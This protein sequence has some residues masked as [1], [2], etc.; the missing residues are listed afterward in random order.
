MIKG[1]KSA[2]SLGLWMCTALVVGNMIGSGVFLLPASLAPY[3]AISILG[4][5]FTSAGAILLALS[6]AR[7]SRRVPGAGGPYTYSRAGFGDFT[8]FLVAWGY[9]ISI[10]SGNAAISVAFASYL[11]VFLPAIG[12]SNRLAATAS[13]LA[14]WTLTIVNIA[15][16]RK[17]GVVQLVTT[18]MKLVPLVGIAIFG[19]FY[20]DPGHFFP[21]NPSNESNFSAVSA[22]AALTLW[23]FLG[24]ESA[25]I[26]A[27]DIRNPSKTIPRSTVIGTCIAAVVYVLGTIA[28]MGVLPREVLTDSIA[29]FSDAAAV[30]WGS[31]A[32]YLVA[33]GAMV[34][35]FGALNG[36]ILLQGQLPMAAARD[37]VFPAAFARISGR[38]TPAVGI[39]VSSCLASVLIVMNSARGLVGAFTFILLLATLTVLFSYVL[40]SMAEILLAARERSDLKEKLTLTASITPALA[41]LY[42]LWAIGGSGR[43]TVYWGFLLLL[44]GIPFYVFEKIRGHSCADG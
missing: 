2:R 21:L 29:P 9:W 18:I 22:C 15:G 17:A 4:W 8:G 25:T 41:F 31:W 1:T 28:V 43:D 5:L 6:F 40:C 37:G 30:M 24:L 42:S 27:D 3:G 10:W 35:A 20:L 38:G 12:A 33:A 19:L 32:A 36:W 34:S 7:L 14:I 23:A 39:V 13:L 26:P 16:V 11:S 44:A